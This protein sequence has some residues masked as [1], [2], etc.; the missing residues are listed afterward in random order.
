MDECCPWKPFVL[1][2]HQKRKAR[3]RNEGSKNPV[4]L[5]VRLGLLYLLPIPVIGKLLIVAVNICQF[6][7][8]II[9]DIM[10]LPAFKK[11][12][13]LLENL[14]E[15]DDEC[16]APSFHDVGEFTWVDT[17]I[18]I[19]IETFSALWSLSLYPSNK[20]NLL[21]IFA[22]MLSGKWCFFHFP[23]RWSGTESRNPSFT[24][25]SDRIL[26]RNSKV[27]VAWSFT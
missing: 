24:I 14:F 2:P 23:S 26:H 3:L 8:V 7:G 18:E 10:E 19:I 6:F 15:F 21:L 27:E 1:Q 4:N 17:V 5:M 22:L 20:V 9:P 13:D 11:F 25:Y 16:D 12:G